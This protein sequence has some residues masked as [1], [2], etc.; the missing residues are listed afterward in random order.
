MIL[1]RLVDDALNMYSGSCISEAR[2]KGLYYLDRCLF[3]PLTEDDQKEM[4]REASNKYCLEKGLECLYFYTENEL[5]TF[6]YKFHG[7]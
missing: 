4:I 5:N 3:E 6:L 1:W 2:Y 7:D